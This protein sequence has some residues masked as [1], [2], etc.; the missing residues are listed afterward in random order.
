MCLS[1]QKLLPLYPGRKVAQLLLLNHRLPKPGSV[2]ISSQGINVSANLSGRTFQ[3]RRLTCISGL[4]QASATSNLTPVCEY[5]PS[6]ADLLKPLID[7]DAVDFDIVTGVSYL[8][9]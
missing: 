1:L 4:H 2:A 3:C 6:G 9:Q 5:C 8:R 7:L